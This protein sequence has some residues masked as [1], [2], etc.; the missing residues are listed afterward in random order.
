MSEFQ[1]FPPAAQRFFRSLARHNNKPWF[2]ENRPV[3]E[4]AIRTPMKAL[5]EDFDVALAAVAPEIVGDPRRSMFRIHRD[6]RFSKDKSPYK[7]NAGCWFYHRA[8]GK[9]VGKETDSGGAGFYFHIDGK[10]SF[11]ASGLWMPPRPALAQIR[12]ALVED[13]KGFEAIVLAPAFKRRFGSLDQESRLTRT[14]RG[15]AADH[16]AAEWL[17][18]QSFTVA[19]G[20]PASA[21]GGAGLVKRLAREAAAMAPFVRWLNNALGYPAARSRL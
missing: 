19:T 21:L 6:I 3:Y 5:I 2:E 9:G 10:D 15:Y 12:E 18:Y 20:I 8:A 14:P 16:P 13:Q 7:T 1:G 17:R 11:F 4:Q